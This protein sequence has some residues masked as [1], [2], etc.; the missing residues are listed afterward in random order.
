MVNILVISLL[1]LLGIIFLPII[2]VRL[3]VNVDLWT[4]LLGHVL[5]HSL[6]Y[7]YRFSFW[8]CCLPFVCLKRLLAGTGKR[9]EA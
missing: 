9:L 4:A 1:V 3:L 8:A 7:F 5:F 6:V 2:L